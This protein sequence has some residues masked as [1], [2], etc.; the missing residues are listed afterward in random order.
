MLVSESA[1]DVFFALGA[2]DYGRIDIRLNAN[3]EPNFL[4]ANLIP[5][6]GATGGYFGRA[7]QLDAGLS[8]E[9]IIM[10]IASLG[11]SPERLRQKDEVIQELSEAETFAPAF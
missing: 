1:K 6:L 3:G 9:E 2:R 10:R 7:G 4:E 5:G 11:L 8:Y